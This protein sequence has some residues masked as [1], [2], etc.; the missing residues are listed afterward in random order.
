MKLRDRI[1]LLR[2]GLKAVETKDWFIVWNKKTGVPVHWSL[3]F[4]DNEVDNATFMDRLSTVNINDYRRPFMTEE[5]VK[6][7]NDERLQHLKDKIKKLDE[8]IEKIK[9]NEVCVTPVINPY[10]ANRCAEELLK[11][12]NTE[13]DNNEE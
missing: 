1:K 6:T 2:H 11:S 3:P 12:G 13:K 4:L 8:E 9:D 5:E 7:F 10:V